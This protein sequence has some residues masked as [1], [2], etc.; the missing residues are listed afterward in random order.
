MRDRTP[1]AAV[2]EQVV[3]VQEA[4]PPRSALARAFGRPPLAEEAQ[5]WFAG[6]L[7]EREVGALLER[8][9]EGWSSFHAIP[10]G[11]GEADVDHLVVGPPGVFVVNTKHHRG[12]RVWVGERAVLVEGAKQPYVRNSELEASRIRRVLAAAGVTAPVNAVVAVV[13]AKSFTVRQQPPRVAVH[14][15]EGLLRWMT[16]RPAVL[17]RDTVAAIAVLFDDPA[18]WRASGERAD[19]AA[20]FAAIEREVQEARLVRTG[21]LLAAALAA[22]AVALPFLPH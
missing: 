12:A 5:P 3:R 4:T 11:A 7:G 20:R 10:V 16:R 14:R 2:M 19:V 6:A 1:G 21:W 8:L 22:V 13:G 17:D 18:T 15:A 9:P